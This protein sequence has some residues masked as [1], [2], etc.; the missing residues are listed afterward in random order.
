[1]ISEFTS[2]IYQMGHRWIIYKPRDQIDDV[3]IELLVHGFGHRES[4]ECHDSMYK[5]RRVYAPPETMHTMR[6]YI[7]EI[8]SL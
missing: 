7:G 8:M 5:M 2:S 3:L 6:V 1:M 4:C